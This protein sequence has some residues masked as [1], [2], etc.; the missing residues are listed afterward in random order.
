MPLN[1]IKFATLDINGITAK[2]R[3]GMLTEFV[4]RDDTDI[5]FAQEVTSTE[6]L[7]FHGYETHLN[8]CASIRGTAIL[9]RRELHLMNI[10]T[11]PSGRAIAALYK[12]IQ[13]INVYA[14]SGTTK[15]NDREQFFNV[16]LPYL[17]KADHKKLIIGVISTVC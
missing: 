14:L 1:V 11:L 15:R 8:I 17:L 10:T 6:V 9:A 2:T 13:L 7:K 12:G 4:R 16:E 3:V 5:L